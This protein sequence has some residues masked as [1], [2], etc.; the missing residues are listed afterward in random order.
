M[1]TVHATKKLLA[2]LPVDEQGFLPSAGSAH[3]LETN[4]AK[5]PGLSSLGSW[6]ANLL[7]IQRRNCLLF[8]HDQTRFPVF[9]PALKKP[10]F[11]NLNHLFGDGLMNTLLKCGATDIQ[12]ER[13]AQHLQPLQFDTV[14]NRSVQGTLNRVGLEIEHVLYYDNIN[15]AE[16]TG[17]RLSA[18][19]ADRPCTVK[20]RKDYLLPVLEFLVLVDA[21][22]VDSA[23]V[24]T[25]PCNVVD[26]A[27][28]REARAKLKPI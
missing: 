26:F 16:I 8:V 18:E 13:A 28:F 7:T 1:I 23:V 24:D 15:V 20:G 12:L 6:H 11:A 22:L 5:H 17:Y 4:D 25:T 3:Y 9:I 21:L 14:C 10:D 27:A 2:K 19:M